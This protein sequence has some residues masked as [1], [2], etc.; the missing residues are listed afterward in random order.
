MNLRERIENHF[1]ASIE[2]KQKSLSSLVDE[3]AFASE[4]MVSCLLSDGKIMSC[5]NGGS[6]ADAQHLSSEML[7]RFERERPA[8]P[9]IALTTDT[10]TLTSIAND[11]H[12][13]DVFS[14]QIRALGQSGDVLVAYT[15]S[16]N[17][18]NL[19]NAISVAHGKNVSVIAI[20]GKDGG[21]LAKLLN[22]TDVEIRV[23]A[24]STARIQETHLLITHCLCD[25][26][27]YQIFGEEL[28]VD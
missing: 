23:P 20:T 22:E 14:K 25:L 4:K 28:S 3:I 6:A 9:A 21:T 19:L 13:D 16:G 24:S 17:S 2:T 1:Y 12:F 15:T 5:G 11:Y 26:I 7:N 8:L 18:P 10:S 27:D